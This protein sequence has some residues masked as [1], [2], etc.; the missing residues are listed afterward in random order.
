M[1][2]WFLRERGITEETLLA[3]GIRTN[4]NGDVILPYSNGEKIR[5][6]PTKP[7]GDRPRFSFPKGKTPGL[8]HA[9]EANAKTVFL[10]EGET[11][12][13]RL[14]QALHE[15]GKSDSVGVVGVGGINTWQTEFGDAF[16]MAKRV[17]VV[18]D[19]DD[20]YKVVA[21]VDHVWLHQIRADLGLKAK[22]IRLP[23]GVKDVCEFFETADL[24]ILRSLAMKGNQVSRFRPLDL[25]IEPP[26]ADWLLDGLVARGDVTLESGV[27]GLGKS[28]VTM[29]LAVGVVE[30]W[31]SF[32]GRELF[33][34]NGTGRVL[35]LD[36]ENPEDVVYDR[37]TRLGLKNTSA[38]RYIWNNGV[39]LDRNPDLLLEEVLDFQPDLIVLDSFT[40]FHSEEEN[41][42]GSMAPL[43]NDCIKPLARETKAA[44]VLIHHHDKGANGPRGSGDIAASVDGALDVFSTHEPGAFTIRLRKSR[45]RLTGDSILVKI[46]DRPDGSAAL[47]AVEALEPPF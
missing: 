36:E 30:G 11:D 10:C 34:P 22:R 46:I 38:L 4:D 28:W 19:N 12:T 37:L 40:R 21:T 1:S 13:M 23:Q 9:E 7:L 35:Y 41:N 29:G 17:F 20:D 26:P 44:V 42:A 24:E 32:M 43:L 33:L 16:K 5:P 14:W 2:E 27:E 15:E 31:S 8:F 25:T 6:N 18:L 47:M 39:R 45:R 3:F